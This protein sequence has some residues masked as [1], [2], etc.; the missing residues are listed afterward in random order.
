MV[1]VKAHYQ[2]IKAE[3]N[4]NERQLVKPSRRQK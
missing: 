3:A 4:I 2:A 1:I